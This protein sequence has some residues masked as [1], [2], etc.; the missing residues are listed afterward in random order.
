MKNF[1]EV[2][3]GKPRDIHDPRLFHKISLIAFLAWVGLGADG[4]SSSA[5]GPDEAFRALSGHTELAVLLAVA[6]AITVFIISYAYSRIIEHFPSGGGGFVVATKLLGPGFGVISG[7]ALLVD[8]V[9]TITVSVASGAAQIFSF[10]PYSWQRWMV[11]VE[12]AAIIVL[13]ILNL[14]GVKESIAVMVPIFLTFVAA[15]LVLIVGAVVQHFGE[16]PAIAAQV[17]ENLHS[18]YTMLGFWGMF[19]ILARAYSR[20]AGTYT[21]IEAVSNGLQIMREPRV[22]TAKRTMIYMATSLAITAGSILLVYLLLNVSEQPG[23]TLNA[24]MV[25]KL[26]YG[27]WYVI[28]VLVSEAALL[29][30][31]AQTGFIDGPRVMA[32]MANDRWLPHRFA[33]LSDRLTMHYGIMLIGGASIATLLYTGGNIDALVT[34]YSINVFITFSLTEIGMVKF[35]ITGRKKYP[36]W[37]KSLPVHATG[38]VLCLSI[39]TIVIIEKFSAGAWMTVVVTSALILL[40]VVI[41]R[42]YRLVTTKLRSLSDILSDLPL[43]NVAV[44]EK[45]SLAPTKPTAVLLV[46]SYSGLGIHSLL[47]IMK[48]FPGYFKQII[49]VSVAVVDSGNFKGADE[50]ERLEQNAKGELARYVQLATNLGLTAASRMSVGTESVEAAEKLCTEIAH[51]FNQAVFFAGKLVFQKQKW[52]QRILHSETAYAI[53]NRLELDGLSMVVLPVRV[54]N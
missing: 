17:G 26:G 30:V 54:W 5:Y 11:P 39:L 51:E 47:N 20:G 14:R 16:A 38:L 2:L 4:L 27:Q 36:E 10:L 32:N 53:Q 23:K 13:V 28:L 12:G 49:F 15:H 52:Y 25:E 45:P 40:C 44:P 46:E 6:T 33:S 42:H 19:M 22:P 31:A 41:K 21:G 37:K 35:W 43:K 9:L 29:F 3:I 8:Y 50:M 18:S 1:K 48:Q 7:S 24:V 34:M